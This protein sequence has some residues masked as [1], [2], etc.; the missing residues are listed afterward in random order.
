M[1]RFSA[2][3]MLAVVPLTLA[4]GGAQAGGKQK[5]NIKIEGK[6]TKDDPADKRRGGASQVHTVTM[7]AGKTYTIDIGSADFD[8]FLR[9]MD[10]QFRKLAEDDDSGGGVNGTDSRIVFTPKA[11]GEYH[12][13]ATTF[14]GEL[15]DFT[16][17]VREEK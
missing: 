12:I 9:L 2:F 15:G 3:V 5:D 7:K 1:A 6:L 8:T 4:L 13:V 17:L 14:S 10:G 11:D 16:L